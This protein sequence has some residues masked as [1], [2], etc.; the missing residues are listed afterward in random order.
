MFNVPAFLGEPKLCAPGE[1]TSTFRQS[2]RLEGK[3]EVG[4]TLS[5]YGDGA[6]RS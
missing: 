3:H 1:T 4:F 5:I 2:Q 6:R